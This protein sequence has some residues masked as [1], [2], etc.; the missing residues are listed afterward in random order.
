MKKAGF[1]LLF[2]LFSVLPIYFWFIPDGIF[3]YYIF[4]STFG[5][6]I[7]FIIF[8]I[9]HRSVV[10]NSSGY[11]YAYS[12]LSKS[13][14]LPKRLKSTL[15]LKGAFLDKENE[16]KYFFILIYFKAIRLKIHFFWIELKKSADEEWQFVLLREKPVA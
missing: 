5:V 2:V 7:T 11:S 16:P 13:E 14:N 4:Q 15:L 3:T 10:L 12:I 8:F 6:G 9:A 1:L